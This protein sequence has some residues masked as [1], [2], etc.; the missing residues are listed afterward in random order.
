MPA[1]LVYR[2]DGCCRTMHY[3]CC[4][5]LRTTSPGAHDQAQVLA[6]AGEQIDVL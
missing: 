6:V 2:D 1:Q 3:V 4:N 5:S